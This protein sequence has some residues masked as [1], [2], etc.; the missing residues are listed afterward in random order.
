VARRALETWIVPDLQLLLVSAQIS[1]VS[2]LV[3]VMGKELKQ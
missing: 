2:E 3:E 1:A